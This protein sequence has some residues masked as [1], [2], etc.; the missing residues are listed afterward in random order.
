MNDRQSAAP[1]NPSDINIIEGKYAVLP[2]SLPAFAGNEGLLQVQSLGSK[3]SGALS[4][5][6][7]VIPSASLLG[8]WRQ[9]VVCKESDVIPLNLSSDDM[10][11]KY[12]SHA[13]AQLSM[14][15]V[16]PASYVSIF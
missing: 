15:A 1:I 14:I 3:C 13:M 12:N 6:Q 7:F 16:N 10:D 5:G 11:G 2:K 4:E 8:T 9:H